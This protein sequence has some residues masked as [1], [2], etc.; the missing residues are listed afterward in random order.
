MRFT[1]APPPSLMGLPPIF[2]D[3]CLHLPLSL[4][5]PL[6]LP[7]RICPCICPCVC[8]CQAKQVWVLCQSSLSKR[9]DTDRTGKPLM[10][11][12]IKGTPRKG[13]LGSTAY[14]HLL[15]VVDAISQR[16]K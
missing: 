16:L 4:H 9:G 1:L 10:P 11:H 14:V 5:L 6:R 2:A 13:D 12:P 3:L 8:A 7:L 15:F